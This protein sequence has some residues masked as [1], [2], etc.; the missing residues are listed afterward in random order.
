MRPWYIK[1]PE[2]LAAEQEALS[3]YQPMLKLQVFQTGTAIT[4]KY[5]LNRSLAVTKG[6]FRLS[7][8]KTQ[9]LIPYQISIMHPDDYPSSPP[10]MYC[11]DVKLPYILDRHIMD[12]GQACLA[13]PSELSKRWREAPW[14]VP[15]LENLVAP[16]LVWQFC[17]DA[18]GQPPSWGGRAHGKP[19]ILRYYADILG[20]PLSDNIEAFIPFIA[21]KH[22]PKGHERCP[23]G[24]GKRLRSCHRENLQMARQRLAPQYAK[25]D[26]K[27]LNK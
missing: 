14:L 11:D 1:N 9:R 2:L 20:L 18:T 6:I 4:S 17:Y 25:A 22:E 19:G 21:R 10:I 15:F 23:C 12:D 13:I 16:F 5:S 26:Q 3:I 24:S 27:V 7:I 8:P